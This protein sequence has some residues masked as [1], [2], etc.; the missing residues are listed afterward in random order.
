EKALAE[1][2]IRYN[3]RTAR[4][5][6]YAQKHRPH[7]CDPRAAG[8]FRQQWKEMVYPLVCARSKGGKL[9]DIDGNEYVDV[10]LGFGANYFG[11]SPDFVVQALREQ[12][13]K[14]FEIGPQSPMAG[15][16]A[17]MLCE[18]TGMERAAFCNTGSEAVMAAMRVA[19]TVTARD[20]IV[21]FT[22]DYHGI[23]D[24]VLARAGNV[25]GQPGAL[26]IAP[27][28][29]PL[30]N[31]MVLAYGDP[32]SLDVIRAYAG[33]IAG[34]LVEPVQSRHPGCQ[35]REFLRAL[36]QLTQEHDIALIFDEVVTG[37]RAALG[38]AQEYFGVRADLA[39]YGKVLG[40]GMPIGVVAGSRRFMDALDGG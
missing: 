2:V 28:I 12:L 33:Q 32:A 22:G 27:G 34:V 39:T 35:P 10:T 7:F 9:W 31:M 29:P 6:D 36:R 13:E 4:S 21:Y 1:L 30:P 23:F 8:N 16:A 20:K 25:N 18:M 15:E 24:E 14:G 38:G 11:H 5:K 3:R 17:Q 37:F 26:P 19:R 40:G